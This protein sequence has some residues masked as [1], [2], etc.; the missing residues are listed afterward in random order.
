MAG[1]G[2]EG[3]LGSGIGDASGAAGEGATNRSRFGDGETH[4]VTPEGKR[5]R[6]VR[7]GEAGVISRQDCEIG[8]DYIPR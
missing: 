1:A 2:N 3:D 7:N 5:P 6:H 8:H 4:H